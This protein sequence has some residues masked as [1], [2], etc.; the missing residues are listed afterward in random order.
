[1]MVLLVHASL[2]NTVTIF[3]Y[4]DLTGLRSPYFSRLAYDGLSQPTVLPPL[5]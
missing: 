5:L 4:V 1:M 2:F 3:K